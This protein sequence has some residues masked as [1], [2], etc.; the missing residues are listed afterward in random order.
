[1]KTTTLLGLLL[2]S[3]CGTTAS[4]RT[5]PDTLTLHARRGTEETTVAWKA[6]QTALIICDM[7]DTHTCAGAAR[8]V[9]AMAPRLNAF[10]AEARRRGVLIVHAPSDVTKFYDGT[11]ARALAKNAP[12]AAAA[13]DFKWRKLDPAREGALPVDDSDWCDCTPKCEIKKIEESKKWPWTR[14][15]ASIEILPGDAL[16]DQGKEIHN[17]F[18]QRG[19]TNV[20]LT[21]VHTN[22]CVLGRSFGIRQQV[23]LGRTVALVRDLTDC[24]YDPRKPPHVSHD[25]GTALLVGHIEKYWCPSVPSTDLRP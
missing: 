10:V 24:L 7:W 19:I 22:M 1:M 5:E 12:E 23:M 16:S 8:R 17:L 14:Q 3:A 20:L 4:P 15:I 18:V 21:G 2:L 6:S 25:E 13:A 11:P 9:A